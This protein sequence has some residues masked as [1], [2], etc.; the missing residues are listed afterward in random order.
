MDKLTLKTIIPFV[1]AHRYFL[2]SAD[3]IFS[4]WYEAVSVKNLLS[5]K[6]NK[7]I[8]LKTK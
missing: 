8:K 2:L 3:R 7:K 6:G 4:R 5:E 1:R